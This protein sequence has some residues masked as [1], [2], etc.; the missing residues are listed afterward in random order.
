MN[1]DENKQSNTWQVEQDDKFQSRGEKNQ[2]KR[3]FLW[4]PFVFFEAS[5]Y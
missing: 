5:H 3:Q 2:R 1:T 4:Q